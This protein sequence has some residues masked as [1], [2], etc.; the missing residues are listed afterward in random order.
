MKFSRYFTSLAAVVSLY[1]CENSPVQKEVYDNKGLDAIVQKKDTQTLQTICWDKT[2]GGNAFDRAYSIQQTTDGGYIVA[3]V[4]SSKGAGKQDAWIFKLDSTGNLQWDKTFGGNDND[5]AYAIQQTTEGGYIVAGETESKSAGYDDAWIFKL[6]STGNVQ[7][8]KTFGGNDF[9]SAK[10][11]RQTTDGGYIVA[12]E[13][14][15]KSTEND[16]WIFKL[17]SKGNMQW[18]KT[19]GGNDDDSAY[20]IQ[21]TTDGG[22]IVAGETESKGAGKQDAWI[23]KLDA[24]GNVQWDKTFG[25]NDFEGANAI[26]QT[27]DGG[28]IVAGETNLKSVDKDD[29]WIFKLDSTGNVQWD[30]IFGGNDDDDGVYSIQQTT[31]G[32]YVVAGVKDSK[33]ASGAAWILKLDATGNLQWDKTFGGDNIKKSGDKAYSIQQTTDGGYV[34]AGDNRSKSAGYHDAWILK[35]NPTGDLCK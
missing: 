6:D 21:Q 14:D 33:S 7:W 5:R 26:Q 11:I 31:D 28:Y 22:Y 4:T 18:D 23:L 24:T 1:A 19:F 9:E 32:G 8:D 27:T 30:K 3:G 35:L 25:G 2:F 16:A 20:S 13:K 15:S 34:V 12:G 29:A 10:A 17:D